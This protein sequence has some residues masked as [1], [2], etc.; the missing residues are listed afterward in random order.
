MLPPKR[1]PNFDRHPRYCAVVIEADISDE[2]A[3]QHMI[4]T[5][6]RD[7]DRIGYCVHSAGVNFRAWTQCEAY[8]RS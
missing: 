7:F 1:A 6:L 3:V 2:D 4:N 5:V 8:Q